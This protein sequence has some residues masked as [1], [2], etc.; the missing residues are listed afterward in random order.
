M[1]IQIDNLQPSGTTIPTNGTD[2]SGRSYLAW[3]LTEK[4]TFNFRLPLNY[5]SGT[6]LA[7]TIE[8]STPGQSQKHK[9]SIDVSRALDTA[10][11]VTSEVTSSAVANTNTETTITLTTNAELNSVDLATG[12]L[13]SLVISRVAASGTED[14]NDIKTYAF[15]VHVQVDDY[16]ASGCLGR[17]G[18]MIDQVLSD[19]ND[20]QLERISRTEIIQWFNSCI[21]E[22]AQDNLFM[23]ETALNVTAD[24]GEI[25]LLS[26]ISDFVDAFHCRWYDDTYFMVPAK[27]FPEFKWRSM[28]S[29]TVSSTPWLWFVQNNTLYFYP[30]VSWSQ[31]SGIYLYHSYL[32]ADI[33]C[34]TDYTPEFPGS[35]DSLLVAFALHRAHSKFYVDSA[36]PEKAAEWYAFY[37]ANLNRLKRQ[38]NPPLTGLRPYR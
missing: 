34:L 14:S 4:A 15:T 29:Y 30:T 32:P 33:G 8:E 20:Q 5:V 7:L 19:F 18:S 11:T 28:Q 3:S 13:I 1:D 22:L 23:K 27:S 21:K 25:D 2:A 36:S 16:T 6:D 10:E 17:V 38:A 37:Q 12:D 31:S 9:W 24:I 35:F 26:T